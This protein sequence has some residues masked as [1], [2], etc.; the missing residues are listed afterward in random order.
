MFPEDQPAGD[1]PLSP[2]VA[3]P[4]TAVADQVIATYVAEAVR[5]LAGVVELHGSAWQELSERVRADIPTK[6]VVVRTVAPGVIEVDAHVQVGWG[7]S[8]PDVA[9]AFQ[10]AVRTTMKSLLDL[11]VQ[12][13][14]LFVDEISPPPELS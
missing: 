12:R 9:C 5:A 7:V 4:Q 8:I 6:G 14:T 1:V 2:V 10:D 13:A 3:E 11:D